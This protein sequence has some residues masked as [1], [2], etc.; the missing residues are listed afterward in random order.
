MKLLNNIIT[1]FSL[2]I[3]TCAYSQNLIMNSGFENGIAGYPNERN[4]VDSYCDNWR[5]F[6]GNCC[7][8]W[9]TI[10][11]TGLNAYYYANNDYGSTHEINN[12]GDNIIGNLLF[13]G[14]PFCYNSLIYK[15][16]PYSPFYPQA[17][18][19]YEIGILSVD[20]TY[21]GQLMDTYSVGVKTGGNYFIGINSD[22]TDRVGVQQELPQK[23]NSGFYKL[24]FYWAVHSK[25]TSNTID[26]YLSEAKNK[27]GVDQ[28][29]ATHEVD[30]NKSDGDTIQSGK[31]YY[32]S[33]IITITSDKTN[34]FK[35]LLI[36]QNH[37]GLEEKDYPEESQYIFFD[38]IS[39]E[40]I[41]EELVPDCSFASPDD[42]VITKNQFKGHSEKHIKN[43]IITQDNIDVT[44][45]AN[46]W[47]TAGSYIEL[48]DGFEVEE[49]A[50]ATFEI[51]QCDELFAR[52][53]NADSSGHSKGNS[54]LNYQANINA[55][56]VKQTELKEIKETV[57]SITP[58][59]STDGLY[60]INCLISN[61]QCMSA[62]IT[63]INSLGQVI[64]EEPMSRY[65]FPLS[66]DISNQPA[67]I[68]FIRIKNADKYLMYKVVKE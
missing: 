16:N 27:A 17:N 55:E 50:N 51:L 64:H 12:Q 42:K 35:W 47:W 63:I 61:V 10:N 34:T 11:S 59:P 26:F 54:G 40:I 52:L 38:D 14:P 13:F 39:L 60:K 58:N 20:T 48:N 65:Q 15:N 41:S 8:D 7:V 30:L 43:T 9:F 36:M 68:Y 4:Q 46:L 3:G 67:G 62:E 2:L 66:L 22:P 19:K 18:V 57:I 45:T 37:C 23:L 6:K 31:W 25:Y 32:K 56:S 49:G 1:L 28:K 21:D 24:S 44:S 29:I 53:S 5:S 33:H